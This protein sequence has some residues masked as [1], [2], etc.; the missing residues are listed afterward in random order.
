[1]FGEH[2]SIDKKDAASEQGYEERKPDIQKKHEDNIAN[3]SLRD[4]SSA[5]KDSSDS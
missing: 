1:L 4:P 2:P 3:Y 5:G